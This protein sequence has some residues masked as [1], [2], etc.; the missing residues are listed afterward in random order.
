MP[1]GET[2]AELNTARSERL[3]AAQLARYEVIKSGCW[4]WQGG[5]DQ[6]GYGKVKRFGKT[7]RAHRLFYEHHTGPVPDGLWVLHR[8]DTPL[9]VNPDHLWVG[10]Q[11]EN[12]QDKD[13]KG[14]RPIPT[15]AVYIEHAG[16]CMH[17]S[18]WERNL[19]VPAGSLKARLLRG[20]NPHEA[21]TRSFDR[22]ESQKKSQIKRT[23]NEAGQYQCII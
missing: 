22:G 15:N 20:W 17:L 7:I 4:I 23:R 12:E 18:D 21:L 14:R 10:T 16:R 5:V 1:R 13:A 11:L 19:G 6:D 9:C 8:C 3:R 2:L